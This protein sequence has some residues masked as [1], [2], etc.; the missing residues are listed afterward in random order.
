[1][2]TDEEQYIARLEIEMKWRKLEEK[3]RNER[4]GINDNKIRQI[5]ET[6]REGST[7]DSAYADSVDSESRS[8]E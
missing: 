4:R 5:E 3:W 2:L 1:M 7:E 8:M 6:G